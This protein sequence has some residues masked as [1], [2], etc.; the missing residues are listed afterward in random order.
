MV[1]GA[2]KGKAA[3]GGK[4]WGSK[5]R[6]AEGKALRKKAKTALKKAGW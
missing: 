3:K 1:K 4:E 6:K 5:A 2:A